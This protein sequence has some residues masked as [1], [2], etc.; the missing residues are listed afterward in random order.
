[1]S[2]FQ[3]SRTA[4]DGGGLSDPRPCLPCDH[5]LLG[6]LEFPSR[7]ADAFVD[8]YGVWD[9]DGGLADGEMLDAS[10]DEEA[11]DDPDA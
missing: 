8:Q 1:M 2:L 7:Q 3:P 5:R 6:R 4:E 9:P 10:W 11:W